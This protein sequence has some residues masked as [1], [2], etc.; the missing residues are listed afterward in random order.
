[1]GKYIVSWY[2]VPSALVST[3]MKRWKVVTFP[4][5]RLPPGWWRQ[6]SHLPTLS[7]VIIIITFKCHHLCLVINPWAA[8]RP[9]SSAP[10][11]RKIKSETNSAFFKIMIRATCMQVNVSSILI[12]FYLNHDPTVE[13][14]VAGTWALRRTE[15]DCQH[16]QDGQQHQHPPYKHSPHQHHHC[17][18][19]ISWCFL[20]L[21]WGL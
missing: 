19:Y 21:S 14:V 17:P 5:H 16:H 11:K 2:T 7:S 8:N 1:M 6:H 15:D 13:H 4:Q 18:H 9:D 3:Q 12:F 10:L 20:S